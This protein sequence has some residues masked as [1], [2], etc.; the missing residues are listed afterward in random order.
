MEEQLLPQYPVVMACFFTQAIKSGLKDGGPELA[1]SEELRSTCC[2]DN[3]ERSLNLLPPEVDKATSPGA[4][5]NMLTI[6]RVL[7]ERDYTLS[8]ATTLGISQ[9]IPRM[10]RATGFNYSGRGCSVRRE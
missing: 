9:R 10:P 4:W 6:V 1:K 5:D 2:L 7:G 8:R 3:R